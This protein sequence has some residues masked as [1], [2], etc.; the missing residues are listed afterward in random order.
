VHVISYR[1]EKKLFYFIFFFVKG[2][3]LCPNPM[4]YYKGWE[5]MSC[6]LV[7]VALG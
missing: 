5:G 1:T 4:S 2:S 7:M 3:A 6:N